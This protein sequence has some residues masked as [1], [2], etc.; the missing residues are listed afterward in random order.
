ME[1]YQAKYAGLG[2]GKHTFELRNLTDA[3]YIDGFCLENSVS[4]AQPTSGPG[5]TSINSSS[6][7]VGQQAS[8][9][10]TLPANAKEVSVLAEASGGLPIR[11]VLIDPAGLTLKIADSANGVAVLNAPVQQGGLYTIK[12]VNISLGPVEVW[13]A[14]TPLVTR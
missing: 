4:Y 7:G 11:L 5:Q 13:T 10:L 1:P 9:S 6:V 3:V 8:S 14:A 2:P 12:V